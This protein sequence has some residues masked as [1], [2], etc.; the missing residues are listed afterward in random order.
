MPPTLTDRNRRQASKS[1]GMASNAGTAR[2][3]SDN[4][5]N[6][7]QTTQAPACQA[8]RS[9]RPGF[10]GGKVWDHH[11]A[12]SRAQAGI[13]SSAHKLAPAL[14][15]S[16]SNTSL[17]SNCSIKA[18]APNAPRC[19]SASTARKRSRS[20][21]AA[22]RAS[23]RSAR[24]SRCRPPVDQTQTSK[25]NKAPNQG[26]THAPSQAAPAI[27]PPRTRPTAGNQTDER[28]SAS[29]L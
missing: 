28:A 13:S 18:M 3:D 22:P 6:Q 19:G 2:L 14:S 16:I 17:A 11:K 26:S 23:N 29:A 12:P 5:A 7:T 15:S 24:P 4:S 1:S 21:W 10:N 9:P 25:A 20:R 27:K 8:K